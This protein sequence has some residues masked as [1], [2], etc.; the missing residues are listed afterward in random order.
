MNADG[1]ELRA[2][3]DDAG[4]AREPVWSPD[5]RRIAFSSD[6][7]SR[8][9]YDIWTIDIATGALTQVTSAPSNEYMPAWRTNAEIAFVSDRPEAPGI[10]A[11]PDRLI[12]SAEGGVEN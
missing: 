6:R 7:I 10:Y 11:A 3:T 4:D 8:S 1:S 5:G 12:A 2:V 9:G